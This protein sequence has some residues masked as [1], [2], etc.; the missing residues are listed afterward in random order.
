MI[1]V[2][3]LEATGSDF[4]TFHPKT[5]IRR[6][7]G[8]ND[9]A[10]DIKYC[11]ICHSDIAQVE[12]IDQTKQP[13]VPG[14]EI[15]GIVNAIGMKVTKYKVGDRVGVGCFVNSCGECQ[16]C[17]SGQEQFCERGVV[18]VFVG[19]DYDGTP[20]QGGYSQ[21]IIVKEHFVLKIPDNLGL[22]EASPLLC[23]GITTYNPLKRYSIGQ[24]SRVA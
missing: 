1:K 11:G 14:H 17:K 22:A 13:L 24:G 6:N 19:K 5:I 20:R 8:P 10:I 2:K 4:S 9:V 7:L 16:Y 23:A 3:A 15:T 12:G 21:S 18:S